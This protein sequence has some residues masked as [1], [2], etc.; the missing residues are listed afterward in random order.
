MPLGY[1]AGCVSEERFEKSQKT[2]RQLEESIALLK[3]VCRSMARWRELLQL[4]ESKTT[5]RRT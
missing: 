4:P 2:K 3:D 5:Q 1:L